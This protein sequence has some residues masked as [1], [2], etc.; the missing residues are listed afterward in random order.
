ML[1]NQST[2]DALYSFCLPELFSRF[3]KYD[4]NLYTSTDYVDDTNNVECDECV[5]CLCQNVGYVR[6]LDCGHIF[7]NCC[8]NE[9]LIKEPTCPQCRSNVTDEFLNND[10]EYLSEYLNMDWDSPLEIIYYPMDSFG[11]FRQSYLNCFSIEIMTMFD[12][13]KRPAIINNNRYTPKKS[14]KKYERQNKSKKNSQNNFNRINKSIC[15]QRY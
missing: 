10:S 13:K 14:Y 2:V 9:W 12:D 1:S 8:I 3:T 11:P 7:H 5:V 4:E 6:K 15:K